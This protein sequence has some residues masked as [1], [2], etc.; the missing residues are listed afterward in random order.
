M[1][2]RGETFHYPFNEKIDD[3]ER[4]VSSKRIN[5]KPKMSNKPYFVL[6]DGTLDRGII[7]NELTKDLLDEDGNKIG[8]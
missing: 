5:Y 7:D 1:P 8:T 4:I 2:M 3:I 6:K